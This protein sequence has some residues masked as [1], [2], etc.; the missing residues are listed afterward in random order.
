MVCITFS[1]QFK[2]SNIMMAIYCDVIFGDFFL[3]FEVQSRLEE[4]HLLGYDAV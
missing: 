1:A 2:I 3:K 4:Y